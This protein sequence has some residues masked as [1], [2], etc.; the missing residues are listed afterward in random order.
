[1]LIINLRSCTDT[2]VSPGTLNACLLA[3]SSCH[4]LDHVQMHVIVTRNE[5]EER[6]S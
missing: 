5:V 3:V 6:L 1:M 2:V 4:F